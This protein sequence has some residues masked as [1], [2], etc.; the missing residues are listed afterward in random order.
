MH[1][2][3]RIARN[4]NRNLPASDSCLQINEMGKIEKVNVARPMIEND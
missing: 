1:I 4:V 2:E 3:P